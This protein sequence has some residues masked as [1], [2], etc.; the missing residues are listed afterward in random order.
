MFPSCNRYISISY[1]NLLD[2]YIIETCA[3]GDKRRPL[4]TLKYITITLPTTNGITINKQ[5]R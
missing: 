1:L 3:S 5:T 2:F 4:Y